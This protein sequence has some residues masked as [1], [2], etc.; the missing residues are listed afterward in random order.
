ME[1]GQSK[2]G[3]RETERQRDRQRETDSYVAL[4]GSCDKERVK[5]K[6][7]LVT[8]EWGSR[9]VQTDNFAPF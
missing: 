1:K 9:A 5:E 6:K 7:R 4:K 8:F 3:N 2:G